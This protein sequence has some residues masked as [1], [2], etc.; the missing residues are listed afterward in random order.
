MHEKQRLRLR[1]FESFGDAVEYGLRRDDV[2]FVE[3]MN[4]IEALGEAL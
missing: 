1:R 3:S 2:F 4:G